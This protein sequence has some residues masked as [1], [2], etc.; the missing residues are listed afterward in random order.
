VAQREEERMGRLEGRTA[1]VT[2]STYGIGESIATILA[3]GGASSIVPG[4][5]EEE[6]ERELRQAPPS[7]ITS[8]R[9]SA[10]YPF[11]PFVKPLP[12]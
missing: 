9:K 12:F 3:G 4:R 8:S 1:I 10:S 7:G 11:I 6:G 2:G 5:P